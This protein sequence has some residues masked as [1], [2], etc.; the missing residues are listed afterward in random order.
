MKHDW[1]PIEDMDGM[2]CSV[3]KEIAQCEEE[4]PRSNDECSVSDA[5][6]VP[7]R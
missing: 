4:W 6:D 1:Q 3:C 5:S 2:R 7:A